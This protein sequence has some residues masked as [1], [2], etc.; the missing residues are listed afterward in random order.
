MQIT[1]YPVP[2]NILKEIDSH[3][4]GY[5]THMEGDRASTLDKKLGI[6]EYTKYHV[7][8][9]QAQRQ[10]LKALD[11]KRKFENFEV[12]KKALRTTAKTKYH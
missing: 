3:K 5:F 10:T 2:K 8:N 6:N 12:T 7:M 11:A 1:E 4:T 9:I